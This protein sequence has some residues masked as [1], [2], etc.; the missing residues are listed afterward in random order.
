MSGVA[1]RR[2]IHRGPRRSVDSSIAVLLTNL[3]RVSSARAPNAKRPRWRA[4]KSTVLAIRPQLVKNEHA[5]SAGSSK[6]RENFAIFST[7][8]KAET[9]FQNGAR[10][11]AANWL[12]RD[13]T[14]RIAAE[15]AD[16]LASA[17]LGKS[18]TVLFSGG[19]LFNA[20]KYRGIA[21]PPTT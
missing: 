13:E 7:K 10:R 5:E 15:I 18:S 11:T 9:N 21:N 20:K 2:I 6:A 4:E 12:T 16:V 19:S 1:S 8:Q 3:P 14:R 17:S